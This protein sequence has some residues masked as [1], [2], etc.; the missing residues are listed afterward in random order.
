RAAADAGGPGAALVLSAVGVGGEGGGEGGGPRRGERQRGI[1]AVGDAP[2][3]RPAGTP[4][5][6]GDPDQ[7]V[8]A[9][10][11]L[12]RRERWRG[13]AFRFAVAAD[14]EAQAGVPAAGQSDLAH[15][16]PA[17]PAAPVLKAGRV[18]EERRV[19][20]GRRGPVEI[21]GQT[22]PVPYGNPQVALDLDLVH[23]LRPQPG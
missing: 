22:R 14:V 6:I 13:H 10:P 4:R 5:L 8:V 18:L 19:A 2:D 1:T 3:S 20:S 11:L 21:G 15:P 9:V 16:H 17:A 23:R 12:A 7:R